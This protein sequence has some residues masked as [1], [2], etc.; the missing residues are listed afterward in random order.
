MDERDIGAVLQQYDIGALRAAAPFDVARRPWKV[1][2]DAGDFVV[3]ECL[4]SN[5]SAGIDFEHRLA[6]WLNAHDFCVSEP[7]IASDGRTWCERDGRLFA[8]YHLV[9]GRHFQAGNATQ[10]RGAGAAL[11]RFHHIATAMPAARS[12]RLPKGYGSAA[13]DA[14]FLM[15]QHGDVAEIAALI[16]DFQG[17]DADLPR[18]LPEALMFNDF[19]P[20]NV[21]FA[22]DEFSG[23]FDVDCCVW[24]RRILDVAMSLLA[25]TLTLEG[26][27]CVPGSATFHVECGRSWLA[28]YQDGVPLGPEEIQLLPLALR[29]QARIGALY[30]LADVAKQ[31]KR[32][33]QHEWDFSKLQMDMVDAHCQTAIEESTQQP[34]RA[35]AEDRDAHG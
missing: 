26:E 11:A 18:S 29:R 5:D 7:V 9:P 19:H 28:G 10:A 6:S 16:A 32:W 13:D 15:C 30:D 24:G 34:H 12:R 17:L 27:P 22:G 21:L 20:G 1:S 25:F 8:I 31:S 23:A 2:V 4:L 14:A 33:V 35:D 3:R